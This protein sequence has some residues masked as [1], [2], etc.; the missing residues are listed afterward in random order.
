MTLQFKIE[1]VALCPMHTKTKAL[2]LLSA[3]GLDQWSLDRVV[4]AGRVFG[5]DGRNAADL[6]FNY[7]ATRGVEPGRSGNPPSVDLGA[8]KPLELEV[9]HY[10][11]GDNWMD[12]RLPG[13]SHIG[14]HVTASELKRWREFFAER[15]ID[16]AQEVVTESHTN[17]AI[18]DSRRYNYVIFDTYGILGVDV[19]F[20]VRLNLDGTPQ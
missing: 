13:V 2:E 5:E 4:A 10:T 15:R 14:M 1:Q 19:K 20:I 17:P 8:A 11:D 18:A 6:A 9:L 3:M 7:Q 12:T 16:V